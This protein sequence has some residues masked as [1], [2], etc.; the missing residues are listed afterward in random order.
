VKH[1]WVS[2]M[3]ESDYN[4]KELFLEWEDMRA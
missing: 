2:H 4:A 3:E 1:E